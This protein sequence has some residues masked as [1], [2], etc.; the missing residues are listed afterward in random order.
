M[1]QHPY[2]LLD[3]DTGATSASAD[4]SKAGVSWEMMCAD[5]GVAWRVTIEDILLRRNWL[6]CPTCREADIVLDSRPAS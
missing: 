2:P 6:D 4:A 1:A 3:D 5:C